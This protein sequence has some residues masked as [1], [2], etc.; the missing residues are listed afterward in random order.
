MQPLVH[1]QLQKLK[2]GTWWRY[3]MEK[4]SALLVVCAVNRSP[5]N[6]PRKGQWREALMFYLICDWIKDWVN[7]REAGDLRSYGAHYDVIVMMD[8]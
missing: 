2:L 3:Q 6:S 8:V 7:N 5:V 4:N 1:T